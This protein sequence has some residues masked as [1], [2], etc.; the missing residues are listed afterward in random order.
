MHANRSTQKRRLLRELL[1]LIVYFPIDLTRFWNSFTEGSTASRRT[2]TVLTSFPALARVIYALNSLAYTSSAGRRSGTQVCS[3]GFTAPG[4]LQLYH[5]NGGLSLF[6]TEA[7]GRGSISQRLRNPPGGF[8]DYLSFVLWQRSTVCRGD[9][10]IGYGA[11]HYI[12]HPAELQER[13]WCLVCRRKLS[14]FYSPH[15]SCCCL[16]LLVIQNLVFPAISVFDDIK[17]KY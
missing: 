6:A 2:P 11:A 8:W 16:L 3:E 5:F 4:E 15:L 9:S 7:N 10:A 17:W 14:H 12:L 13:S 1:R